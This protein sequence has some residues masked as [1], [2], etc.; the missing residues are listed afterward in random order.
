MFVSCRAISKEGESAFRSPW[1]S[2]TLVKISGPAP[3]PRTFATDR[4]RQTK[5]DAASTNATGGT[6][7]IPLDAGQP[8]APAFR[9]LGTTGT[10]EALTSSQRIA[11]HG[12]PM[13]DP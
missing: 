3:S 13:Y 10:F 12:F 1:G 9:R 4:Y 2:A 5:K 11:P 8:Q 6:A 7:I